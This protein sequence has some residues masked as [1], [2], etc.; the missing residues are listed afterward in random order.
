MRKI[1]Q[2]IIKCMIIRIEN[3]T[4]KCNNLCITFFDIF[5][6]SLS[7]DILI[8]DMVFVFS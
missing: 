5:Q 4:N 8:N 1:I 6:K 7:Y 2:I 3:K